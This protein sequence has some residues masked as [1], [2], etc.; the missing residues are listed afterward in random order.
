MMKRKCSIMLGIVLCAGLLSACGN[1]F[2]ADTATI[3]VEKNGKVISVD[4]DSFEED[5]YDKTEL[6]EYI[7]EAVE[8]YT[9]DNGKGS[10]KIAELTTDSEVAKLTMEYQS[11]EDYASF[12]NEELFQGTVTEALAAGYDFETVFLKV[13]DGEITE[14]VTTKQV[15]ASSDL[16]V[17][18]TDKNANIKIDGTICYVSENVSELRAEDIA[19]VADEDTDAFEKN[20]NTYIIY[21]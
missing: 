20:G 4:V 13:E 17:V 19:V 10:V 6:Q 15:K 14:R 2:T 8:A 16:K 5:Y 3:Y 12:N 18:I 21:K 11:V 7:T 1:S 9:K